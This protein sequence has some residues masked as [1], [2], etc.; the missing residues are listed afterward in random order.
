VLV[1]IFALTEVFTRLGEKPLIIPSASQEKGFRFPPLTDWMLRKKTL[2]KSSLIGTFIGVLPGTGAATAS[3]I[4]Y[5]EAKRSG[6]FKEKLGTGEPE[7]IIA[8]ESANNAVTGGA[9]VPTLALGIP[10]DPVTAVLMSAL[11]I[12]GIQPGVRL[13]V[14][15]GDLMNSVFFALIICNIAMFCSGALLSRFVTKILKI[16]EVLLL[17]MVTILSIIGAYTVNGRMFDVGVALIA[18]LL[19][20]VMRLSGVPL[21]PVVIGLV[22]GSIFEENLR[23]GLIIKDG[24]F[25]AF[26]SFDHPIALVL[27]VVTFLI[28]GALLRKE[29][30]LSKSK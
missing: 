21:A 17:S 22:L 26:F 29:F 24:S 18:G 16:P 20:Y 13:F 11:I 9:L 28:L 15:Y 10:G 7:G 4:S 19:G 5:S 2:I 8:S 23:Q 25:M 3:F 1:G 30:I 12:Q 27:F 14:D 6:I